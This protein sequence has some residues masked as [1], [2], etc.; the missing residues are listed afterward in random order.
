MDLF[1][2]TVQEIDTFCSEKTKEIKESSAD[3]ISQY[4]YIVENEEA[5]NFND[6][7]TQSYIRNKSEI[8]KATDRLKENTKLLP[9]RTQK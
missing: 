1:Q 2:L 7:L 6:F 5:L 9:L 4:K 8:K 3:L